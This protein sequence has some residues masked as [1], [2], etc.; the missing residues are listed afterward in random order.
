MLQMFFRE[1]RLGVAGTRRQTLLFKS[2]AEMISGARPGRT[3]D[4]SSMRR[5]AWCR[6]L[7]RALSTGEIFNEKSMWPLA[8]ATVA[9]LPFI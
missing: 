5:R 4:E 1:N 2:A 7:A 6:C 8:S 3:G 9:T